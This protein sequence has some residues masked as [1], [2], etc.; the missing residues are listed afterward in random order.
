MLQN[1][2]KYAE[3][4]GF[5]ATLQIRVEHWDGDHSHP[6]SMQV[7]GFWLKAG[8]LLVLRQAILEYIDLP[9]AQLAGARL[10]GEFELARLPG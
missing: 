2:A 4:P 8:E 9:L 10:T 7:E 1:P 3:E 5:D 6:I